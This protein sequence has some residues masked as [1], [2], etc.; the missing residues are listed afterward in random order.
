MPEITTT[1]SKSSDAP[2]WF[3]AI[4]FGLTVF[5]Y[6]FGLTIPFVGPDEPRYA[7]VAREMLQR[8][9]WITPTL[10]GFNWF[11]KPAL[12]YW[13]EIVSYHIFGINEF[14][15]RFG[16]ALCGLGTIAALWL[17]GRYAGLESKF[18]N[19]LALVAASTLGIIVFSRGASF[20]IVV[21]FPITASLAGFIIHETKRNSRLALFCFYFFIGV[22]L[23]A[24][25]L[26]GLVFPF[27]IVGLYFLFI[28]RWPDRGWLISCWESHPAPRSVT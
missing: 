2:R 10:G 16:P 23:L 27:G 9:D 11:E 21:T 17:I 28:K 3:W 20:D 6:L 13:L 8:G 5:V 7:E 26:I 18:A 19:L 4:F 25:G 15:A 24:K 22:A 12:L 1:A 14:A